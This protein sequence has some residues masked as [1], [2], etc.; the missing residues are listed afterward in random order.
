M[1]R[2]LLVALTAGLALA[3]TA[4]LARAACDFEHPKSA[5]KVQGNF[6]QAFVSCGNPGG[7]S[8]NTSNEGGGVPTCQ[9]PETFNV[10]AGNPASG[11]RWDETKGKGQVI[12]IAKSK[13]LVVPENPTL[14]PP[15][16]TRDLQVKV[17]LKGVADAASATAT[18]NGFLATVARAT[19]DDR[20]GGSMTAVDFPVSFNVPLTLGAANVKT[21]ADAALNA[22]GI[23]GLPGC[24][25]IEVIDVSILD[26]NGNTF[27]HMGT[28]LKEF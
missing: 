27:A 12:F 21:S 11:W 10:Q 14:N 19:F 8:P 5:G 23:K 16:D 18:G 2:H 24:T 28:Y 4:S 22:L 3:F 13:A 25:S 20:V 6:I 1:R 15:G 9:P 26:E 17:K 7:N